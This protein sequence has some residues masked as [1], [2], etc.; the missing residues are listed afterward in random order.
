MHKDKSHPI[1]HL[2][3]HVG[4]TLNGSEAPEVITILRGIGSNVSN[5]VTWANCTRPWLS[6]SFFTES[7]GEMLLFWHLS[8]EVDIFHDSLSLV[9]FP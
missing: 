4:Y 7:Y 8:S 5:T 2:N 1:V 9:F 3:V 6:L